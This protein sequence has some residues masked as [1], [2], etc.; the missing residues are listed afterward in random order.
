MA[1]SGQYI[2][3]MGSLGHWLHK[4]GASAKGMGSGLHMP[5]RCAICRHWPAEPLCDTC[6]TRFAHPRPRCQTCALPVP[7][8]VQRC[9]ECLRHPPPLARCLCAVDYVWPWRHLVARYKFH[10]QPG[11]DRPLAWLMRSAAWA[12]DTLHEADRVLPIPLARERLAERG[13]NQAWLLARRLAPDKADPSLLLRIRHTPAQRTLPRSERLSN[14]QGAFA[15]EPLRVHALR[16]QRL[17]LVDDVMTS[18]AS[19]HTAARV[20]LHA[21]A[22]QVSALVLARTGLADNDADDGAALL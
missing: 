20:L 15:V 13:Y 18:G 19:L 4:V 9:G 1:R 22:A 3:P 11:W 5:S 16:G 14:L 17:L 7:E 6:I 8:G 10:A 2:D 21:G 12:E